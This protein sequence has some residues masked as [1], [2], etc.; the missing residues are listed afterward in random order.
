MISRLT[1]SIP[2]I[3]LTCLAVPYIFSGLICWL[4]FLSNRNQHSSGLGWEHLP[5]VLASLVIVFFWPLWI[6]IDIRQMNSQDKELSLLPYV[7]SDSDSWN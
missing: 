2:L 1:L 3:L 4:A 5:I 6:I 7:T